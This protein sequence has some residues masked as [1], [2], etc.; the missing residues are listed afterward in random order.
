MNACFRPVLPRLRSRDGTYMA[1]SATA[2]LVSSTAARARAGPKSSDGVHI[3][4]MH[5]FKGLEYQRIILAGVSDGFVPRE[6]IVM[7]RDADPKRYQRERQRDRSLLFV[8]AT[9]AR[10][11]LGVT[12][13]GT[14]SPFLTSRLV[15]PPSN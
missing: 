14:P 13:H 12:W 1:T 8:A 11:E 7:Y 5:R 10:D 3:G 6:M 15:H 9:R 4:T 2:G